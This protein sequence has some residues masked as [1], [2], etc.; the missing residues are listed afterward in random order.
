MSVCAYIY[1]YIYIY[2]YICIDDYIRVLTQNHPQTFPKSGN[3]SNQLTLEWHNWSQVPDHGRKWKRVHIVPGEFEVSTVMLSGYF[4]KCEKW[5]IEIAIILTR[6]VMIDHQ[7]FGVH[8]FSA[9]PP[10]ANHVQWFL[11][12]Q[13]I[14]LGH[15]HR[16]FHPVSIC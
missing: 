8:C 6:K 5:G 7:F 13:T 14:Y 12:Q 11:N 10:S 2:I 3:S 1:M 15:F 16:C 4:Q 9:N